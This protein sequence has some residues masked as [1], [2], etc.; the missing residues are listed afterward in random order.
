MSAQ[1]QEIPVVAAGPVRVRIVM[2]KTVPEISLHG[3]EQLAPAGSERD[4]IR[5]ERIHLLIGR[6]AHSTEQKGIQKRTV[7]E[8]I[9]DSPADFVI[10]L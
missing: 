7:I 9:S 8:S 4:I 2:R 10:R 1:T 5:L 6:Q 3:P